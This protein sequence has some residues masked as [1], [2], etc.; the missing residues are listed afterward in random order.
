M[1]FIKRNMVG[2]V[3]VSVLI[4]LVLALTS[5]NTSAQ[6]GVSGRYSNVFTT[7]AYEEV[8]SD[9]LIGVITPGIINATG[10]QK[11][12]RAYITVTGQGIRW[13]AD[14]TT[15]T[16]DLG[17]PTL[18]NVSF[19]LVGYDDIMNFEFINDDGTGTSTCHISLQYEK[20]MK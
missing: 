13:T 4:L 1:G 14:G 3:A 12:Q 16:T 9:T 7:H 10:L 8:I 6:H 11:T 19:E 17:I 18:V 20:E 2:V 15:P 5:I